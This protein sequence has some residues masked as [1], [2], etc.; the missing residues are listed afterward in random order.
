[1]YNATVPTMLSINEAAERTNL[2]RTFIRKL[3]WDNKITY[4]RSGKK[5]LVNLEKLCDYLNQQN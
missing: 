3:C 5:Y 2:P 4:V 1:M